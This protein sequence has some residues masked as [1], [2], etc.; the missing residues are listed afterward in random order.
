MFT[1]R[2]IEDFIFRT[3]EDFASE[4]NLA[5][6]RARVNGT[7]IAAISLIVGGIGIMNIMLASISERVREIGIRKA[8]GASTGAVFTQ[9]LTEST[10]L[11]VVGGLAGLGCSW[12]VVQVIGAFTPTDN[13]PEI[14][15]L[16]LA[17]AFAFSVLVGILAGLYPALRASRFHPIQALRY[18]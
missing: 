4:I 13:A 2:G 16:A 7:I 15:V 6:Q 12:L 3:Q 8:V 5:I 11:S 18:E 9:I 10:V 17:V 1:H 14:T